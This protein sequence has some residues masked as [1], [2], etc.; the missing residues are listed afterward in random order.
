MKNIKIKIKKTEN[1]IFKFNNNNII[2]K[3]ILNES[4]N[5]PKYIN[6]F[7]ARR[8]K[9]LEKK[10][11]KE[12]FSSQK[13]L[14]QNNSLNKKNNLLLTIDIT[15]NN[16]NICKR[17]FSSGQ[18]L[19]THEKNSNSTKM[20]NYSNSN[21]LQSN[22]RVNSSKGRPMNFNV[23]SYNNLFDVKKKI[24][25]S[26]ISSKYIKNNQNSYFF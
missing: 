18:R 3:T 21:T 23:N 19:K 8:N 9:Y 4:Y 11:D 22:F 10:D 20:S 25:K 6:N 1:L 7:L 16:S 15:N 14:K 26:N 17:P 24:F 12:Y 5:K 2:S 13:N